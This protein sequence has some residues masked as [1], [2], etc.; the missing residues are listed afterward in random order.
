MWGM[1]HPEYEPQKWHVF[2]GYLVSSWM[3]CAIVLFMNRA[4]PMINNIGL[5]FI[6]AG[7][8]ITILV[9]AITVRTAVHFT[10][11]KRRTKT[12]VSG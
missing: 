12:D 3:C 7:V 6:L 8:A 1:Y 9:C 11:K 10:G 4:L 5:V 2:V